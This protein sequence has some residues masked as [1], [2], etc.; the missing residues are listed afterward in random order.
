MHH[1][2]SPSIALCLLRICAIVHHLARLSVHRPNLRRASRLSHLP[3]TPAPRLSSS[4]SLRHPRHG[5]TGPPPLLVS[6]DC[7]FPPTR[8]PFFSLHAH[9]SRC[10][11]VFAS[12]PPCISNHISLFVFCLRPRLPFFIRARLFFKARPSLTTMPPCS[13]SLSTPSASAGLL[14]SATSLKRPPCPS[15]RYDLPT[16]P[17]VSRSHPPTPDA[18]LS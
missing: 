15:Y 2:K 6:M 13:I 11:C 7:A 3:N 14:P 12:L 9:C 4:P 16:Y 10:V 1:G 8:L 5:L 18:L 17:P